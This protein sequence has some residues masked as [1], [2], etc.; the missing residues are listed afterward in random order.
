MTFLFYRDDGICP[1]DRE[2]LEIK[3]CRDRGKEKD[4]LKLACH[5]SFLKYGCN[6]NGELR[7]AEV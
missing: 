6:W 3:E 4:I 1:I 2:L 7:Y 5:C